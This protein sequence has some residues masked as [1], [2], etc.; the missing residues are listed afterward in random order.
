MRY[1]TRKQQKRKNLFFFASIYMIIAGKMTK[2]IPEC[3]KTEI[4]VL[5][6]N[7]TVELLYFSQKHKTNATAKVK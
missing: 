6:T 1:I 5:N 7:N 3:I 2:D 4:K